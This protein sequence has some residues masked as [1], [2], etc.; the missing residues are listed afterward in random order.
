[1]VRKVIFFLCFVQNKGTAVEDNVETIKW[2][3]VVI[4]SKSKTPSQQNIHCAQVL[5]HIIH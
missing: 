1:M 5:D 4:L 3:T 2:F